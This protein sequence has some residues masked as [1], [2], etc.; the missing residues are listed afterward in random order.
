MHALVEMGLTIRNI[1]PRLISFHSTL[2]SPVELILNEDGVRLVEMQH[3]SLAVFWQRW[4]WL[5]NLSEGH[6]ASWTITLHCSR[7]VMCIYRLCR[8][9]RLGLIGGLAFST[10]YPMRK[11]SPGQKLSIG[12]V[13]FKPLVWV[14]RH[15]PESL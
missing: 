6:L 15:L 12:G 8:M 14:C 4:P 5:G 11:I 10:L 1:A 7:A 13:I 9:C 2:S 3:Q